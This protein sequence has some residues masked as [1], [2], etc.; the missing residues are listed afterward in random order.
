MQPILMDPFGVNRDFGVPG[1]G[2][3][4]EVAEMV[5]GRTP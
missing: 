5:E 4:G 3:L 1:V 2:S